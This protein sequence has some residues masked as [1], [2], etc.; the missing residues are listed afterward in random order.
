MDRKGWIILI[1]CAAGL[2]ANFWW[3]T[4]DAKKVAAQ[5]KQQTERAEKTA[6]SNPVM[7]EAGSDPEMSTDG[8]DL[9]PPAPSTSTTFEERFETL[10]A[11]ANDY[12]NA[13]K[14]VYV[15]TNRGG[16]L[17]RVEYPDDFSNAFGE[18]AVAI[19]DISRSPIGA[20]TNGSDVERG[21]YEV[22]ARGENF[23][24][25]RGKTFQGLIATKRYELATEGAGRNYRLIL[26]VELALP[27]EG[28]VSTGMLGLHLGA[29]GPETSKEAAQL[30]GFGWKNPEEDEFIASSKFE[31][32]WF[33]SDTASIDK[34]VPNPTWVALMSQFYTLIYSPMGGLGE[35]KVSA[36]PL[37]ITVPGV[38][39]NEEKEVT[40]VSVGVG[41]GELSLNKNSVPKEFA[42][43]LYAGPKNYDLLKR[44]GGE[45][46]EVLF[47]GDMPVIGWM[48][49]PFSRLLNLGMHSIQKVT[50]NYGIAI[51]C[52]TLLI[53][54]AL[55]P[56]YTKSQKT[57][58]RMAK[59]GP[60]VKELKEKYPD[61]P[62]KLNQ[63]TMELYKDYGVSP[64]GGCLPMF[65]QMPIFFGFYRMLQYAA[66]LRHESFLWVNDLS[67]PDTI[68]HIP[69]L[70]WP[71][72]VLPILMAVSMFFQMKMT[73]TQA[74]NAQQKIMM[75]LP[76]V[77]LFICYSFA[78]ALAL[79]WT[80][81]NIFS[82][83]QTWWANRQPEVELVKKK[84]KKRP[85]LAELQKQRAAAA[86]GETVDEK[87]KKK[88]PPRP[89]GK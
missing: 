37:R 50:V 60:M 12:A 13:E 38:K 88:R 52:V 71:V 72:N 42:L 8:D 36:K 20:L 58:K 45:R 69:G 66:E 10:T 7:T 73:P 81:Q 65:L 62:Q 31:G 63:K 17:A 64:L 32:G 86:R 5:R 79:Y 28:Q 83:G 75:F 19:N 14:V 2:A 55:W 4:E 15:F 59:I 49:A 35:L 34:T 44:V 51:I 54:I 33:S 18:D 70:D 53:R 29:M 78:S 39:E 16:G 57:M 82:I 27:S 21:Q 80:T 56:L 6:P 74:D 9:A 26:S 85:S 1:L 68:F 46:N 24:E 84:R 3:M 22:S 41:L 77:F 23:I 11:D 67:Q 47:Y 87:P 76:F 25:Y 30:V 89:G 40:A 61:D 48:A 43:E